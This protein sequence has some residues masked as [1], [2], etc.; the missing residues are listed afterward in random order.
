[1]S[2]IILMDKPYPTEVTRGIF[3]KPFDNRFFTKFSDFTQP[4][5]F[6]IYNIHSRQNTLISSVTGSGKTLGAFGGILNELIDSADK[7]ILE[8]K[9]Y[10]MY[11][12]PL[13]ALSRDIHQCNKLY[14]LIFL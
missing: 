1:M 13:R 10:C 12:S 7:G 3:C 14:P 5:K 2:E 9:V 4:Q 6:S 8:D 11:V